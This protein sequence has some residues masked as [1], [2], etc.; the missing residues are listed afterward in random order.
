[1]WASLVLSLPVALGFLVLRLV[2]LRRATRRAVQAVARAWARLMLAAMGV[3]LEVSGLSL[4]PASG[5]VVFVGNHQ[6]DVDMLAAIA[7]IRRPFGFI[8]KKEAAYLPFINLWALLLDVVF[9][10]R[11]NPRSAYGSIHEGA[12]RVAAGTGMIIFP[13]GTRSRS[14]AMGPFRPGALKLA[15]LSAATV[16]P[17]TFDGCYKAWEESRRIRGATVAV[18][19][20]EAIPAGALGAGGSR[21][22]SER[23]RGLIAAALPA[24]PGTGVET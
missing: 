12:R 18:T 2:G 24:A 10:D 4:V 22:L 21:A 20:H 7:L 15:T 16:V 8:A 17:I 23:V 13:E 11:G 3:R 6:G 19:F 5:P 9:I 1:M 14:A